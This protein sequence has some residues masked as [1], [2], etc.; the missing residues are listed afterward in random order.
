MFAEEERMKFRLMAEREISAKEHKFGLIDGKKEELRR[1]HDTMSTSVR[2]MS[3]RLPCA[4][5]SQLTEARESRSKLDS[6]L[7]E[8]ENKQR[9]L[10]R[11][12]Y[13][14]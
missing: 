4:M 11:T 3:T 12:Q 1:F 14:K 7:R 2:L 5:E 10:L 6:I 13:L 8:L 9:L